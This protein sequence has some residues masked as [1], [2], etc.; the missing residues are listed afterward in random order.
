MQQLTVFVFYCRSKILPKKLAI[1]MTIDEVNELQLEDN[2]PEKIVK[3]TMKS[4]WDSHKCE[5][6][7]AY[8]FKHEAKS[9]CCCGGKVKIPLPNP[10]DVFKDLLRNSN[11]FLVNIRAYNNA[12]SLASLGIDNKEV[13]N[14]SFS[15]SLKFQGT[16]YHQIG[17]LKP[18]DG[19][20]RKF[21]QLYI[22]DGT[23]DDEVAMRLKAATNT[24]LRPD[25]MMKLQDM[26]HTH[27]PYV[28]SFKAL[29][30]I[31]HNEVAD[32]Q[33]VIRKDKK[34]EGE[35]ERRFNLP[36]RNEIAVI[37]LNET[38]EPADVLIRM[39]DNG[40][41]HRISDLHRAFDPLRYI[42]LFPDGQHGWQLNLSRTDGKKLTALQFYNY[43]LQVRDPQV[44][45][46][47][48]MRSRRL[49]QE[50][51]LTSFHRI[52][53]QNLLWLE[54]NQKSIKA[55]KYQGVFDAVH[56]QDDLSNIG[57]KIILPGSHT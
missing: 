1:S 56:C 3:F 28:H 25:V 18:N 31:P 27:N 20:S 48:I 52:E 10:P 23:M 50:Y 47:S 51:M 19:E 34:P 4:I 13:L 2:Y 26:L 17:P 32:V 8:L 54:R 36:D 45:F 43:M 40:P 41:L 55:E 22:H 11:N 53:R 12:L 24:N 39:K 44:H 29:G 5:H 38:K 14:T 37:S 33:F 15:P 21:A 9:F 57:Q 16:L 49:C 35:H 7:S 30:E 6:C 42:L 46:N